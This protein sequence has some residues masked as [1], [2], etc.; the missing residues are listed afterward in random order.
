MRKGNGMSSARFS[1]LRRTSVRRRVVCRLKA[2]TSTLKRAPQM[3]AFC[4]FTL[5]LCAALDG[6]LINVTLV[7]PGEGGMQTLGSA[8]SGPGGKFSIDKEV[9]SPPALLQ[10]DY[11]GVTY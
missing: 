3:F 10:A 4:L 2:G 6:T 1:V 7:H 5:P 9:P 8:K 11:Q